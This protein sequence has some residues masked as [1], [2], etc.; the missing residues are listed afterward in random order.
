MNSR[1]KRTPKL[2]SGF[3][4]IELL[5]VIAIIAI[6]AAMLLPAL[7]KAKQKA[8]QTS[9]QNNEK[10][11]FFAIQLWA[12]DNNDLL[13]PGTAGYGLSG[14]NWAMY[15]E[16]AASPSTYTT[17]HRNL[18]YWIS[19]YMGYPSPSTTVTNVAMAFLCPGNVAYNK[20][21]YLTTPNLVMYALPNGSASSL[22]LLDSSGNS[23]WAFGYGN[24]GPLPRKI[25]TL[26]TLKP[27]TEYWFAVDIDQVAMPTAWVDLTTGVNMAPS[28]PVHGSV[29]NY[30]YF[31]GHVQANKVGGINKY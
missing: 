8:Y 23:I 28:Q 24:S 4:L 18:A 31:D 7:A 3:T 13:P 16:D 11:T 29:R 5:V 14:G 17:Q 9:C 21:S 22:Q 6:L 20:L 30:G 10:Q 2:L 1:C 15:Y 19:T 27:L 25:N 12:D 26:A